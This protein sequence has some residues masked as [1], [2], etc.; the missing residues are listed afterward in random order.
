MK[1]NNFTLLKK[2]VIFF[3]ILFV[4]TISN[5]QDT[6]PKAPKSEFWKKVRFGLGGG[7]GI[8]NGF[9]NISLSPY[10]VY[11]VNE[12][13][14]IGPGIQGSY[15]SGS[16]ASSFIYGGSVISF[17]TPIESIQLSGE[18]EQLRVS[19]KIDATS[20]LPSSTTNFWNT[21]LFLGAGYRMSGVIIG[22]RYNVLFDK[23][24]SIYPQAFTP[25]VRV[26]F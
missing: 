23:D 1:I 5:A 20:T 9:T 4:C 18:I 24:E 19:S 11:Q 14:S 12:Y 7:L 13:F 22:I 8:S 3:T 2:T 25:F 10:A 21:A 15:I 17:F 16:D 6:I 26:G